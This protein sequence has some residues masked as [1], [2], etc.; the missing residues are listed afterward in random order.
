MVFWRDI[1]SLMFIIPLFTIAR[2]WK[3]PLYQL[4]DKWVMKIFIT[5]W[6][7]NKNLVYFHMVYYSSIKINKA[8]KFS[9]KGI[10]IKTIILIEVTKTQNWPRHA[11]WCD[12]DINIRA[13]TNQFLTGMKACTTGEKSYLTPLLGQEPTTTLEHSLIVLCF[14]MNN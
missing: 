12:S 1:C 10:Y 13:V 2:T 6:M 11:N 3:W 7:D 14:E 9:D 8:M 4:T 5:L